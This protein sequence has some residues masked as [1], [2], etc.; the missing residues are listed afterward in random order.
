MSFISPDTVQNDHEIFNHSIILIVK[1]T[2]IYLFFFLQ[3][4]IYNVNSLQYCNCRQLV[5]VANIRGRWCQILKVATTRLPFVFSYRQRRFGNCIL[6]PVLVGV[7]GFSFGVVDAF[8][9]GVFILGGV[10]FAAS[11]SKKAT[12]IW[13]MNIV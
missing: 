5:L 2:V 7:T 1:D 3:F 4:P 6:Q 12:S 10:L 8:D 13:S 11:H 9:W